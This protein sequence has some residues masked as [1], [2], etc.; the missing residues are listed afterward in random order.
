MLYAHP[1]SWFADSIST[2]SCFRFAKS[3]GREPSMLLLVRSS[4]CSFVNPDQGGSV[5]LQSQNGAWD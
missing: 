1:C 2:F 5:P 3:G 4:R